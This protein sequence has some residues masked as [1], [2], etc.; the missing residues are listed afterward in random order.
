V[1]EPTDIC[2]AQKAV[3]EGE[4]GTFVPDRRIETAMLISLLRTQRA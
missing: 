1:I 2:G 3:I 4:D